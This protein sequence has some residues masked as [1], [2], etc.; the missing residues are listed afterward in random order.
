MVAAGI[1][2]LPGIGEPEAA[3]GVEDGIVGTFQ[4]FTLE[5]VVE[6]RYR[7]CGQVDALD[8]TARFGVGGMAGEEQAARLDPFEPAI[9][10]DIG[11]AVGTRSEEHTSELQSLMRISYAVFCL[12]KKKHKKQQHKKIN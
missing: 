8:R 4:P 3:V 5:T 6:R 1:A 9:V 2:H 12:K 7:A 11:G 10:A